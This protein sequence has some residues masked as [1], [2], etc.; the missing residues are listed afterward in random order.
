MMN[1]EDIIDTL[2]QVEELPQLKMQALLSQIRTQHFT[3]LDS[4]LMYLV[5]QL[6]AVS[7]E[8]PISPAEALELGRRLLDNSYPQGADAAHL[9][10]VPEQAVHFTQL[11]LEQA[12]KEYTRRQL[13]TKLTLILS[14][15][16]WSERQHMLADI[17]QKKKHLFS[18]EFTQ[19]SAYLFVDHLPEL[20]L[21]LV[22]AEHLIQEKLP[23]IVSQS[24]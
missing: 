6:R 19:A 20:L 21:Q 10:F 1:F 5:T 9:D 15:L 12:C 14:T 22:D 23:T 24:S 8:P 13:N 3:R 2:L 18:E 4:L 17:S 11:V 16:S 7:G